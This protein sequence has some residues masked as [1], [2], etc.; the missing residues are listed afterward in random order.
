MRVLG[1]EHLSTLTT[2]GNVATYLSQQGKDAE[3]E[4]IYRDVLRGIK[5]L[6]GPEHPTTITAASNLAGT[7]LCQRKS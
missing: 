5:R 3:A 7:L 2:G 6:L 1:P 4:A